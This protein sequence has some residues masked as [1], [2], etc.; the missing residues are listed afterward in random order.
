MRRNDDG[1]IYYEPTNKFD[2][3]SNHIGEENGV[4]T[5]WHCLYEDVN[6]FTDNNISITALKYYKYGFL[7]CYKDYN[8]D[9]LEHILLDDK[10]SY[11]Q[12]KVEEFN[13]ITF[14]AYQNCFGFCVLNGELWL[15]LTKENLNKVLS[16]DNY[17]EYDKKP[18]KK[19]LIVYYKYD[20][21]LHIAKYDPIE[22]IYIHKLGCNKHYSTP[23]EFIDVYYQ[24]GLGYN[25]IKYFLQ[26]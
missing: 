11:V 24:D 8:K 22:C 13:T 25:K 2:I 4:T 5:E 23:T 26:H 1:T 6:V 14:N 18:D 19:H 12:T 20:E 16:G 7:K 15:N 10:N 9:N 3:K 21:P 17:V